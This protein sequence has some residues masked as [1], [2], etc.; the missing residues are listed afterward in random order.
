MLTINKPLGQLVTLVVQACRASGLK[1][2]VVRS[3]LTEHSNAHSEQAAHRLS[4]RNIPSKKTIDEIRTADDWMRADLLG[5]IRLAP[6]L[7]MTC[8]EGCAL[9][10]RFSPFRALITHQRTVDDNEN[11][12]EVACSPTLLCPHCHSPLELYDLEKSEPVNGTAMQ[13]VYASI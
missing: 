3:V 1:E 11:E 9:P 10:Y 12:L 7:L 13:P 8:T 6:H 2:S 5:P 4:R